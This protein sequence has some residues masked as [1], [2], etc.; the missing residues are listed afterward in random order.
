MAKKPKRR[1]SKPSRSGG[2]DPSTAKLVLIRSIFGFLCVLSLWGDYAVLRRSLQ[3]HRSRSWPAAEG[4]ILA[5]TVE[6]GSGRYYTVY[7]AKI[8]YNYKIGRSVYQNDVI[9]FPIDRN[10]GRS[11]AFNR[12]SAHP[13]G[14]AA[15]IYYDPASPKTPCLETGYHADSILASLGVTAVFSYLLWKEGWPK[16][17]P[18]PER[19][20]RKKPGKF[21][22]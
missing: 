8:T 12:V 9:G 15:T 20:W 4:V 16:S 6:E 5:S 2:V 19:K 11:G 7:R 1:S 13:S 3:G 14:S 10:L 22:P 18:R 21:E 17:T